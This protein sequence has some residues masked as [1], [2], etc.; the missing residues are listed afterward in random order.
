MQNILDEAIKGYEKQL[1]GYKLGGKEYPNYITNSEWRL[2]LE[3]MKQTYP[4]IHEAFT[5]GGGK[6][7]KETQYPPK[8]ASYGS[9]SRMMYKLAS[10]IAGFEFEKQ[11]PTKIGNGLSNL[12]GYINRNSENCICVEAKCREIY[13]S[14]HNPRS[15]KYKDLLL[16]ISRKYEDLEI[17][18]TDITGKKI[19][20]KITEK[21]INR[22]IKY[23]DLMQLICHFCGIANQLLDKKCKIP[24]NIKFL[25]VIYN[26]HEIPDSYFIN[27]SKDKIIKRYNDTLDEIKCLDINKLFDVVFD[28]FNKNK[29]CINYKFTFSTTDQNMFLRSL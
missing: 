25:Y 14:S 10:S 17:G 7:L 11:F 27:N 8:M 9:S 2:F 18:C 3:N 16:F 13:A 1:G 24:L 21:K 15:N 28:F 23:F 29:E 12:D 26:P 22:E 19:K 20:I 6:E 4:F 5:N